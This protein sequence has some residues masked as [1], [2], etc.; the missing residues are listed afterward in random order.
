MG[1][2]KVITAKVGDTFRAPQE[3]Y[4]LFVN[5]RQLPIPEVLLKF[6][7]GAKKDGPDA[8]NRQKVLCT[9]S[10][11]FNVC[12]RAARR[13]LLAQSQAK[14]GDTVIAMVRDVLQRLGV[15]GFEEVT[16][17][18][19]EENVENE[20]VSPKLVKLVEMLKERPLGGHEQVL[21]V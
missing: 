3:E 2:A 17:A 7:P 11:W 6:F 9:L 20:Y 1:G 18:G 13:Y 8:H 14:W 21:L 16:K 5:C 15:E 19:T 10:L 12:A 4:F